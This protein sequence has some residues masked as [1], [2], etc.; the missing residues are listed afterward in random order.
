V[1]ALSPA[2]GGEG[3]ACLP[4]KPEIDKLDFEL[5]SLAVSAIN[6]CGACMKSHERKLR[7]ELK[8]QTDS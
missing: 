2:S 1:P 6:G 4:F 3:R 7:A 8:S 5:L